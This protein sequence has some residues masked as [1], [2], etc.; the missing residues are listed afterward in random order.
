MAFAVVA[1]QLPNASTAIRVAL[2]ERTRLD[3]PLAADAT[4]A[5][6]LDHTFAWMRYRALMAVAELA[7]IQLHADLKAAELASWLRGAS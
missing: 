3:Q 7:R 4:D 5:D 2:A 1:E 6:H